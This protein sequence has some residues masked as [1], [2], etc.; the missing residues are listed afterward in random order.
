MLA[1]LHVLIASAIGLIA[2]G[3]TALTSANPNPNS[4]MLVKVGI[5]IMLLCWAFIAVMT[6]VSLLM[7]ARKSTDRV[8][9]HQG[10][11]LR[12]FTDGKR[13]CVPLML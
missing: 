1:A 4:L 11:H 10:G 8:D 7:P 12:G 6:A 13:V 9:A 3:A 5:V 2:S